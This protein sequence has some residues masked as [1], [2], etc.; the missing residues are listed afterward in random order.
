MLGAEVRDN[1]RIE[2][3]LAEAPEN[4]LQI[5]VPKCWG[6]GGRAWTKLE[7]K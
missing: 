7:V 6:G 1:K 3:V 5:A 4:N 2:M